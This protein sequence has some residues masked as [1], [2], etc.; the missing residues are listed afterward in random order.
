MAVYPLSGVNIRI[1]TQYRVY[2]KKKRLAVG[3]LIRQWP[4]LFLFFLFVWGQSNVCGN[5][6]TDLEDIKGSAECLQEGLQWSG[7]GDYNLCAM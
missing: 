3:L 4:F 6:Q 7:N 2:V 5:P 1:K